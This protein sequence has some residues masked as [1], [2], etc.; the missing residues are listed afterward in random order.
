MS[1]GL[2]DVYKRQVHGLG[3]NSGHGCL[4]GAARS[5]EKY[6][7]GHTPGRNGIDQGPG[8]M[9]LVDNGFKALGTIF[10]GEDQ[11]RHKNPSTG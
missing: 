11:I 3:Q 1:R 9:V 7:V 5:G 2:G 8:H 6:G 4:S 10:S